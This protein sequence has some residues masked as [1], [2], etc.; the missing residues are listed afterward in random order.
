MERD[1]DDDLSAEDFQV[2]EEPFKIS[3]HLPPL[4]SV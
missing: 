4:H 3:G 2:G 1:R